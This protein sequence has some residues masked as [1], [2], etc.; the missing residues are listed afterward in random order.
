MRDGRSTR[1]TYGGGDS[2]NRIMDP[3]VQR[4]WESRASVRIAV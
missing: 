3:V 4:A 1:I 2:A